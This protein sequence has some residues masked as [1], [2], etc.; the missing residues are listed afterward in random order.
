MSQCRKCG[1][2]FRMSFKPFIQ[3][4]VVI[5]RL[6]TQAVS[7][8]LDEISNLSKVINN[9]KCSHSILII[10]CLKNR[11]HIGTDFGKTLSCDTNCFRLT[12]RKCFIVILQN[13]VEELYATP[14]PL[15]LLVYCVGSLW[16]SIN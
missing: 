6:E 9:K 11:L 4:F 5:H 14:C 8:F 16:G 15:V 7:N 12:S 2:K 13:C 1:R 10:R 3:N